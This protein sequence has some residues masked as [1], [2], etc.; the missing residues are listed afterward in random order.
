[1]WGVVEVLDKIFVWLGVRVFY[2]NLAKV[3]GCF[4]KV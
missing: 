4:G 2:Y 3:N 1:M